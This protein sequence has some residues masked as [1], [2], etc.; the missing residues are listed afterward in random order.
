MQN[1]KLKAHNY[2]NDVVAEYET[3]SISSPPKHRKISNYLR[4]RGHIE[5]NLFKNSLVNFVNTSLFI[6]LVSIL[7]G[8]ILC[9]FSVF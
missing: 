6:H 4:N 9:V 5:S 7:S 8:L 1:D 2:F 3:L